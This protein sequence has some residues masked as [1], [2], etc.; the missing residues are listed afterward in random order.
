MNK[1]IWDKISKII[2]SQPTIR[3]KE[4]AQTVLRVCGI[5]DEHNR[6]TPVYLGVIVENRRIRNEI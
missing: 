1:D 2:Q 4:E 5:L 3:S 6:I